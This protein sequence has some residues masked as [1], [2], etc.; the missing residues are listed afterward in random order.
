MGKFDYAIE[1]LIVMRNQI[2]NPAWQCGSSVE[3]MQ[4]KLENYEHEV[5]LL[6]ERI[7][8][9]RFR[10]NNALKQIDDAIG[11][12]KANATNPQDMF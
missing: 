10:D 4:E 12:L 1:Q 11:V 6:K 7:K 9:K 3:D 2:T 5:V 8:E